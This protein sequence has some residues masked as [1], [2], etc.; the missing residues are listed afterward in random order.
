MPLPG[1]TRARRSDGP[2]ETSRWR[3]WG[4]QPPAVRWL[5]AAVGA[6]VGAVPV[7]GAPGVATV[8]VAGAAAVAVAAGR[9]PAWTRWAAGAL[10]LAVM[11][12][13][14]S[15]TNDGASGAA[16]SG[17]TSVVGRVLADPVASRG[18]ETVPLRP[19]IVDGVVFDGPDLAVEWPEGRHRAQAGEW[20]A[21][22]GTVRGGERRIRGRRVAATV[23]AR[24][25]TVAEPAEP[26]LRAGNGLRAA[27]R[28]RLPVD[29]GPE[30]ALLRGFLIGDT[31]G[32]SPFDY[33][34][35]R[36]AGLTHFVAVSGSN[37]A[38]FLGMWFLVLAPVV[39]SVRIRAVAGLVAL[40]VFVVA[41]R[42][43]PSVVRAAVMAGLVL[44]ARAFGVSLD[45]WTVL[46][47][48]V[49]ALSILSPPLAGSVGFQL[50]VA[51]TAGVMA[52]SRAF[53]GR[54]PR[55][56]ATI[57]G[58]TV[59]A[60]VA[61]APL[62]LVHFGSVPLFAPLANLVAAPLVA[63]ATAVG[64]VGIVTGGLPLTVGTW[65]AGWVIDLAH[66]ASGWPQLDAVGVAA[67]VA[68][69]GLVRYRLGRVALAV[70][71]AV[72]VLVGRVGPPRPG[73]V[74]LDVGQGDAVLVLGTGV[75]VL[76]DA[77]PDPRLLARKLARYG[78]R[79]L[80]LVVASHPHADHV[81]GLAGLA[82][83]IPI[84]AVWYAS[85]PHTT[86]TWLR[87]TGE[88]TA[89]G[90]PIVD[91]G[92]GTY[93]MGDVTLDVLGPVRRYAS[94][95]D[96]SLVL[97]VRIGEVSVLLPGDV[98]AL[99]QGELGRIAADVLAVPHQGAGTS[100][101]DWLALQASSL[102]VISVG[103]NAYGHPVP[104]V[105]EVLSQAGARVLRT[106]QVG[107]VVVAPDVIASTIER[108]PSGS[109]G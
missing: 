24:T 49:A 62:L 31:G 44:V 107:D 22:D 63:A 83:R 53:V 41:T 20:L 51:A 30:A 64:V 67:V 69:A 66:L 90:I 40:V 73:V 56:V 82:G 17:R 37:V 25:V 39:G 85:A 10:L 99:A 8:A 68:A 27:V 74:F 77:G 80:D 7:A 15:G 46:G 54:L 32:L 98:E 70:G 96:Q 34:A 97:R 86:D 101:P 95:N 35:M 28:A 106:D 36:R 75:N 88:L 71:V 4:I 14:W 52:G 48:T 93:R 91:P 57:L 76:V 61:V 11:S 16:P 19:V 59:G 72:F 94:P 23:V 84:G 103:P 29:A 108:T 3:R 47:A 100:D 81:G 60:Q 65:L 55:V 21:V 78:V 5:A 9:R 105:E 58:P 45:A 26:W 89:A 87:L 38:L 104:W 79:R 33:E 92:L 42:W 109:D 13:A 1:S 102:A 6:W 50:S 43:E 12:A 2:T 18:R